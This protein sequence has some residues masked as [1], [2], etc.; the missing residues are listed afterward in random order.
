MEVTSA[1]CETLRAEDFIGRGCQQD[2]RNAHAQVWH[3]ATAHGEG[4]GAGCDFWKLLQQVGG[5]HYLDVTK[6]VK[7]SPEFFKLFFQMCDKEV[8]GR[9]ASAN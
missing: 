2:A 8:F 7:S 5:G 9:I 3:S 1:T 4:A 6:D